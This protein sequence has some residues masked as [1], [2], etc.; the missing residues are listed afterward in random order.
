M[1]TR[2][3]PRKMTSLVS[4]KTFPVDSLFPNRA[5][6]RAS[7]PIALHQTDRFTGHLLAELISQRNKILIQ[8]PL[9]AKDEA[10]DKAKNGIMDFAILGDGQ[11]RRVVAARDD[12]GPAAA[13][14]ELRIRDS[15]DEA[16]GLN[17]LHDLHRDIALS[18]ERARGHRAQ[19]MLP[20]SSHPVASLEKRRN[21]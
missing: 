4:S 13:E 14:R 20:R 17:C 5:A 21:R 18:L 16:A 1:T 12:V 11:R 6:Q 10:G 8:T 9:M 19:A 2:K 3:S 15:P 7:S